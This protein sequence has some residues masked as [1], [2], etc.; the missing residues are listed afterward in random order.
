[1]VK[2][3]GIAMCENKRMWTIYA[4]NLIPDDKFVARVVKILEMNKGV[5]VNIEGLAP[6]AL[7]TMEK[8]F[9]RRMLFPFMMGAISSAH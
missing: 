6:Q 8:G 7:A 5:P 1:M 2:I 3:G 4:Y 9:W